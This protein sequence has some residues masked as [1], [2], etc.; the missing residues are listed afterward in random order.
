MN[1]NSNSYEIKSLYKYPKT[2]KKKIRIAKNEW[3]QHECVEIERLQT[4]HDNFNLHKKLKETSGIYE[5]TKF[6]AIMD[7]N[8]EI[9]KDNQERMVIW[10]RYIRKLFSDERPSTEELIK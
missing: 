8:G 3:L 4:L 1:L 2:N 7:E 9:P 5:K 6:S 10:E